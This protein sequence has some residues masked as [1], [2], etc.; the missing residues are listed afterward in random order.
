MNST[1]ITRRTALAGTAAT[2][3]LGPLSSRADTYPSKIITTVIG[4]PAG[5]P[6]DFV[7]RTVTGR[8]QKNLGQN[9]IVENVGGVGGALAAQKVL[10][11]PA[12]GYTLYYAILSDLLLTPLSVASVKYKSEDFRLIG[13]AVDSYILLLARPD[14][15]ANTLA[16]LVALAKSRAD[17]PLT[18][19]H[20]GRGGVFHLPA[21]HFMRDA[22]VKLVGVPYRGASQLMP[23]LVSGV[24][25]IAFLA[26]G[27][28]TLGMIQ[29][30]QMKAIAFASEERLP[31]LPSLP[32]FNESGLV[33]DFVYSAWGGIAVPKNTPEPV[34]QRLNA[35]L[36]EAVA[37][38]D[39]R[40]SLQDS[41]LI[42]LR[43]PMS[44][45]EANQFYVSE[46]S[47]WRALAKSIN[48][49]PE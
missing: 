48:L 7:A 1:L 39:V 31:S 38:R 24:V 32:T 10:A 22:G 5:G 9:M 6:G 8:M 46:T 34:A 29:K 13:K 30:G 35:A 28:P 25:D 20:L 4:F 26:L 19:G 17:R 37:D 44:L 3:I 43:A 14:L 45:A 40:K 27:G 36:S 11:A 16:E 21:E 42:P 49:Q 23:D 15:P 33:K 41:G 12:D 47:R 2:L 18:V